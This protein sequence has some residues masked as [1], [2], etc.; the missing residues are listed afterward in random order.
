MIKTVP[1]KPAFGHDGG[2]I[3]ALFKNGTADN[4]FFRK[5]SMGFLSDE[6]DSTYEEHVQKLLGLPESGMGYQV[7]NITLKNG[8]QLKKRVVLNSNELILEGNEDIA[9]DH[10]KEIELITKNS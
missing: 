6:K 5:Y 8:Q 7:V 10:I 9:P 2:G 4:T 3:E 1:P